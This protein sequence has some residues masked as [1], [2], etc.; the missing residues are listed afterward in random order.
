MKGRTKNIKF[1]FSS[2]Y[3]FLISF[4]LLALFLAG[5]GGVIPPTNQLPTASFTANPTSGEAPLEVSFDASNSTDTDGTIASYAWDFKDGNTGNGETI[6]HTFSSSGS[7]N[8]KLNVTDNEGATAS[9]TKTITVTETTNQAPIIIST[10]ITTAM[11]GLLY[12]YDVDATDPDGDTITYSFYSIYTAPN[13]M[14]INSTTGVIS[15]TPTS[16]QIGNTLVMVKVSDGTLSATQS[17]TIVV[18]E[19]SVIA[20]DDFESG[21]LQG[22]F[23]WIDPEWNGEGYAAAQPSNEAEQ[24]SYIAIIWGI[25]EGSYIWRSVDLSSAVKPRLQF[26]VKP[27]DLWKYFDWKDTAVVQI[28]KD[29]ENWYP[30]ATWVGEYVGFPNEPWSFI[31]YDLS[32]Y[33][34]TSQFWIK[35]KVVDNSIHMLG[36]YPML[37]IDDLKIVDLN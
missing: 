31:D 19:P 24:G 22:G 4:L 35:F 6:N 18:S 34:G 11:I 10:P 28:S 14:T 25:S 5:C 32:S 30:I 20:E 9:A 3:L 29:N 21:T 27:K 36:C 17:F 1:K 33:V 8:V 15:W 12:T 16:I 2:K 23:G 37:Y 13:G 7:Y 26:W